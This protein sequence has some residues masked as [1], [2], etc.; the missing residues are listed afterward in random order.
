MSYLS[1][2]S[3]GLNGG[4]IMQFII[5]SSHCAF[6]VR[7]SSYTLHVIPLPSHVQLF[8]SWRRRTYLT[9][10]YTYIPHIHTH[11]EETKLWFMYPFLD[12]TEVQSLSFA[13]MS[14]HFCTN[15]TRIDVVTRI[16]SSA[17]SY[18][19]VWKDR[20]SWCQWIPYIHS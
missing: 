3:M 15:I 10:F 4:I 11:L 17:I 13:S 2:Y 1:F 12:C 7:E 14:A 9:P 18:A 16:L 6:I 20:Y 5:F 8:V 19:I